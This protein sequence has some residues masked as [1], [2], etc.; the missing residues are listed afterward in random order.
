MTV[1]PGKLS[2]MT[3]AFG[4]SLLITGPESLLASRLVAETKRRALAAHPEADINEIQATELADSMLSEVVGGSLF[5]SHIIAIIDDVG[6]CPPE[7]VD[8]L[9]A[10]AADPPE[11]LCL[12]LVHQG[13]MKGK[14]LID[15][16]KKAKV[17]VEQVA[18]I[19]PWELPKFV[20][21]EAKRHKVRIS[22]EAAGELVAAVGHDLRSLAGAVSQLA[23]DA[24]SGEID[25]PIIR[26]YFA[27]RAEVTS[28]A[29]ADA[30]LAGNASLAL[31]RLRW[32]LSTGA[33]PV[34][35]TSAMAGAFRGMGRYLDAQGSRMSDADLA[36]QIGVPFWKIK[37]YSRAAR[38]W[39]SASVASAI[40]LIGTADGEV[41]GAATNADFAL[42]RMVLGVLKL[43]RH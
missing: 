10:I 32:A 30:V 15:K 33:A 2:T 1:I 26:R 4:T 12:I 22:Q 17:K 39:Q 8:Q 31:E 41:K 34:L 35:V 6:A 21:E 29:V 7:V 37:D 19:K 24:G 9:V 28:F 3:S 23:S 27:G 42:E 14:G 13:G 18:A 20:A 36:R 40:R 16:L 25:V 43:R 5:S 38:N 11:D